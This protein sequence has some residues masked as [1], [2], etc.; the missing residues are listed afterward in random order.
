[1]ITIPLAILLSKH[2]KMGPSGVVLA[3]LFTTFPTMILW[4]IQYKKIISGTATGIWN[5]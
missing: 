4:K 1:V 2:F 3:T 5:K